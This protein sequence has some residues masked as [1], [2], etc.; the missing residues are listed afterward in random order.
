MTDTSAPSAPQQGVAVTVT[1]QYVKDLSFEN[2]NAP[3]IFAANQTPPELAMNVNVRS[4][5]V[6]ADHYEVV[7]ALKLEAKT[8]STTA[9]IAE[10]SYG[11]VFHIP[12][13]P[14]DQLRVFLLVE[15]PRLL[16][17]FARSVLMNAVRDGGFP[18]VMI[19]PVDFLGLYM[20]NQN[21]VG[22]M[23]TIGAA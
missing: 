1:A 8:D 18:H 6:A 21:N 16:F 3:Q 9:F 4:R 10:L 23:P 20:A 14:E 7:L 22:T 2:P 19:S 17:P 11:G 13:V 5:G 15:A 12:T